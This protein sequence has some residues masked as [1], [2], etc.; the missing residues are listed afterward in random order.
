MGHQ[1][2]PA[3]PVAQRTFQ[4]A[5]N[6]GAVLGK[7][8]SDLSSGDA[9]GY[10]EYIH[11]FMYSKDLLDSED[12]GMGELLALKDVTD[13]IVQSHSDV[14]LPVESSVNVKTV[15]IP[16]TSPPVEL[17]YAATANAPSTDAASVATAA[18]A[19]TQIATDST[20][21][22][23]FSEANVLPD[24]V[25]QMLLN[26]ED[27]SKKLFQFVSKPTSQFTVR[28]ALTEPTH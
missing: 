28:P 15:P 4:I 23:T 9:E 2:E 20:N 24:N 18:T 26:Y 16:V 5:A 25:K 11:A 3:F 7:D 21:A 1:E 14:T 13:D 27:L 17:V 19:N 22:A 10:F 12:S 8:P 6:V